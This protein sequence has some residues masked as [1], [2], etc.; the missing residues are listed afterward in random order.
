MARIL[1]V[2]DSRAC[3]MFVTD[4]I[5]KYAHQKYESDFDLKIDVADSAIQA[6]EMM[7]TRNYELIITDIMMSRMDGWALL[8]EIR[9]TKSKS[10]LPVVIL[11]AIESDDLKYESVRKGAVDGFAKPLRGAEL[12]RFIDTVFNLITER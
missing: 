2:E 7:K 8:S 3:S 9:K 10:E 11:S 12:K 4:L 6:L 5:T 1:I